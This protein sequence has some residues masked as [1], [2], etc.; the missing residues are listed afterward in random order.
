MKKI[1]ENRENILHWLASGTIIHLGR[2]ILFK[3]ISEI[4]NN[5]IVLGK[6]FP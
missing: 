3:Y 2:N 6:E 4:F 1:F 5:L